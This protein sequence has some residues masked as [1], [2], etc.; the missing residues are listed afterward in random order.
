MRRPSEATNRRD[1]PGADPGKRQR[2]PGTGTRGTVSM[3]CMGGERRMVQEKEAGDTT[4]RCARMR[5][6]WFDPWRMDHPLAPE[7]AFSAEYRDTTDVPPDER[8]DRCPW[9]HGLIHMK[10][11]GWRQMPTPAEMMEAFETDAPDRRQQAML[12]TAIGE[13]TALDWVMMHRHG[14]F[15]WRQLHRAAER[16]GPWPAET[17]RQINQFAEERR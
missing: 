11:C 5:E 6:R 4:A 10:C 15:T 13:G 2:K 8:F 9:L 12:S 3:P 1:Q 17:V 7:E 14:V 16:T